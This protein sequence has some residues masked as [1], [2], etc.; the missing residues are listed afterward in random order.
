MAQSSASDVLSSVGTE[1][2]LHPLTLSFHDKALETELRRTKF[3]ASL[4]VTTMALLFELLMHASLNQI[5]P[6]IVVLSNI[7]VP[8]LLAIIML[9]AWLGYM[10]DQYQ[11]H[12]IF[13]CAWTAALALGSVLSVVCSMGM[14]YMDASVFGLYMTTYASAFFVMQVQYM[15]FRANVVGGAS[16]AVTF[17]VCGFFDN[18]EFSSLGHPTEGLIAIG[19]SLVGFFIGR[20]VQK[21]LRSNFA[22]SQMI[23]STQ[24][25]MERA[26][27]RASERRKRDPDLGNGRYLQMGLIGRGAVADVFLARRT[28][29][30]MPHP[31]GGESHGES[32]LCAVKRLKKSESHKLEVR[33]LEEFTIM[34]GLSHPFLVE[35][36]DAFQSERCF[37]FVM[38]YAAG[39]D[40]GRWIGEL[41]EANAK[42]VA[43]EVR[44][45]RARGP[46]PVPPNTPL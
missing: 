43:A 1:P 46:L 26:R 39:G 25:E 40:L 13:S 27:S 6:S 45:S 37:Y 18:A 4:W 44:R 19:A 23:K 11:A 14:V 34:Q 24:R 15:D 22:A 29:Q 8:L 10:A 30:S 9:R 41:E 17:L 28:S 38:T 20:E 5:V 16:V 36:H 2:Q 7:W 12:L 33:M 32:A 31:R 21:M 42:T 35:L 3:P